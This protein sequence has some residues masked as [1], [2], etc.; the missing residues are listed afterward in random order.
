MKKFFEPKSRKVFRKKESPRF[1]HLIEIADQLPFLKC[2]EKIS[3][4]ESA[5]NMLNNGATLIAV[6][7][8]AYHGDLY[9]GI[10]FILR[11]HG[12]NICVYNPTD[13][14]ADNIVLSPE[15]V[16]RASQT[17]MGILSLLCDMYNWT[18]FYVDQIGFLDNAITFP[19]S[20]LEDKIATA[21]VPDGAMITCD[22]EGNPA[23]VAVIDT[24]QLKTAKLHYYSDM[25][26]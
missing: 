12:Q 21:F 4:E 9:P 17:G 5:L 25:G 13:T 6:I 24:K 26:H 3:L 2:D 10:H 18:S 23:Q 19:E 20:D 14:F 1:A 16:F 15:A 22:K 7:P 11:Q 8:S